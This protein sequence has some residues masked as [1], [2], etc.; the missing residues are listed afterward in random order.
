MRGFPEV[1]TGEDWPDIVDT[2]EQ[3]FPATKPFFVVF[4][5]FST[6]ALMNLVTGII[7]DKVLAGSLSRTGLQT[8]K[9]CPITWCHGQ[10]T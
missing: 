8:L 2:T 9:T 4:I 3:S 5:L 7:V 10:F 1:V 6:F